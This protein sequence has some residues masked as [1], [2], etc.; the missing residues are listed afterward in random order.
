V[1]GVVVSV[2]F[3]GEDVDADHRGDGK[4]RASNR[5]KQNRM[6]KFAM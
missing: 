4:V 2:L 1:L 6:N 3:G 5:L